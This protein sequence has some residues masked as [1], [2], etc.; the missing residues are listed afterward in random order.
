[1]PVVWSKY[2]SSSSVL[3]SLHHSPMIAIEEGFECSFK[4]AFPYLY[5]I[6]SSAFLD[7][8][9]S[10]TQ[11]ADAWFRLSNAAYCDEQL[12]PAVSGLW[13]ATDQRMDMNGYS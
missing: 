5:C 12:F 6:D 10:L 7:S 11:I 8:L 9:V 3:G 4:I 2:I 1:M 13:L